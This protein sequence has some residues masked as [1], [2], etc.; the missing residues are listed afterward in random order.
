MPGLGENA[1]YLHYIL[2]YTIQLCWVFKGIFYTNF[3]H[4]F[5][6]QFLQQFLHQFFTAI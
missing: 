3:L 2:G 4:Q 6:H 5:L 1:R